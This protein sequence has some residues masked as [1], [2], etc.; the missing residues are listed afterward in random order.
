MNQAFG[1]LHHVSEKDVFGT[2]S[3]KKAKERL[4]NKDFPMLNI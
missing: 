1:M 2:D 3:M 4:D